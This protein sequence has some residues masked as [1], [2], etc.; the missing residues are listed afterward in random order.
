MKSFQRM[1]T[2]LGLIENKQVPVLFSVSG[3]C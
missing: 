2:D 1:Y 3:I